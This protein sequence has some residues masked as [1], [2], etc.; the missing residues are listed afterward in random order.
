M[1]QKAPLTLLHA[2]VIHQRVEMVGVLVDFGLLGELWDCLVQDENS[3]HFNR[4]ALEIAESLPNKKMVDVLKL[5][6]HVEES[7][8]WLHRCARD[9]NII[10]MKKLI[11]DHPNLVNLPIPT[12]SEVSETPAGVQCHTGKLGENI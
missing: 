5:Q 10:A 12:P 4:T 6:K 8:G 11:E 7:L 3:E 2:A 1:C 9:G